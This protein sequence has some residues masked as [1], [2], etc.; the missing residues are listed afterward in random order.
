MTNEDITRIAQHLRCIHETADPRL[1]CR[2]LDINID[3]L[4]MG[5]GNSAL[6]G[7][8]TRNNRCATISINSDQP[9]KTQTIVLFHEI[10]HYV[11]R[12]HKRK[13]V[14]AFHDYGI[15]DNA[16]EL[17]DEANR[18]VAEYLL[19]NNETLDVLQTSCD[20]FKASSILHVPKEILDYKMRML[21]YYKL[22]NPEF[23]E[24]PVYSKRNFMGTIDCSGIENSDYA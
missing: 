18:F 5:S 9:E 2:C 4:P 15:F 7:L 14:C 23:A 3:Y 6:K 13:Q 24:C 16:S 8:I 10:G 11:L 17:E 20:F 12:H 21:K 22:L 1:L 19:E